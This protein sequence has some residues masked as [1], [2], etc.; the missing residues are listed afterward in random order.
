MTDDNHSSARP[1][2]QPETHWFAQT[3]EP[4]PYDEMLSP[5]QA[6]CEALA[7]LGPHAPTAEVQ[8]HLAERGLQ[9]DAAVIDDIRSHLPGDSACAK[10]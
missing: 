8:R 10:R 3:E 6:V 9:V 1:A 5:A 2:T 4:A 7:L